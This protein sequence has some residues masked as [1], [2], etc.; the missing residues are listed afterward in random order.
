MTCTPDPENR[1]RSSVAAPDHPTL[2][3]DERLWLKSY[4]E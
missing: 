3:P 4:F 2:E 1:D